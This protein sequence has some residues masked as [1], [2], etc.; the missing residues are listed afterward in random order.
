MNEF[1]SCNCIG[2]QLLIICILN[3]PSHVFCYCQ[4]LL[5]ESHTDFLLFTIWTK[6]KI[7]IFLLHLWKHPHG[8]V[9]VILIRVD[10]VKICTN[11]Q[12]EALRPKAEATILRATQCNFVKNTYEMHQFNEKKSRK[13]KN[14]DEKAKTKEVTARL[15]NAGT[16][17][18]RFKRFLTV[19]EASWPE[20][21]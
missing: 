1:P 3:T 20:A 17:G 14:S 10:L 18:E 15:H 4:T 2:I 16:A 7:L 6:I 19:R 11:F 9:N 5:V 8:R 21:I 13:K 12:R